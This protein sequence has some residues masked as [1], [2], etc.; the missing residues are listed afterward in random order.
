MGLRLMFKRGVQAVYAD[1]EL[2]EDAVIQSFR[3][4]AADGKSYNTQDEMQQRQL[5]VTAY[6]DL[7][8]SM[9]QRQIPMTMQDAGKVSAEIAQ[10][11]ALNMDVH[12]PCF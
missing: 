2:P 11:H 8:E 1:K 12:A 10:T 7:A 6:L 5:L 4:T 9:A 3:I